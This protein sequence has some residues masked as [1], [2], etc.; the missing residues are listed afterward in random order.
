MS[1][2]R[3]H[4]TPKVHILLHHFPHFTCLTNMPHGLCSEQVVKEQHARVIR[5]LMNM[6]SCKDHVTSPEILKRVLQYNSTHI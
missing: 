5:F 1:H 4:M 2:F 6:V 3:L